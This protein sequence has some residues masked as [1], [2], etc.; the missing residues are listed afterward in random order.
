MPN[1][2]L[3]PLPSYYIPDSASLQS[4]K[5]GLTAKA[6]AVSWHM[7]LTDLRAAPCHCKL[8]QNAH[9]FGVLLGNLCVASHLS[10]A[11]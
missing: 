8:C 1:Y 7:S 10:I 3:S 6:S 11:V 5:V 2:S 9:S 4:Y